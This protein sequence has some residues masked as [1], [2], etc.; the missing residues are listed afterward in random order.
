MSQERYDVQNPKSG[1]L[2]TSYS[3]LG[4]A[5]EDE[6]KIGQVVLLLISR[7][8]IFVAV[9]TLFALA[10]VAYALS[11][12]NIYEAKAV[13][14]ANPS[15][16]RSG[17]GG[18]GVGLAA[19]QSAPLLAL[20]GGGGGGGGNANVDRALISFR[21]RTFVLKMIKDYNLLPVIFPKESPEVL[22]SEEKITQAYEW[23]NAR[24][25][26][27]PL[28][29]VYNLSVKHTSPNSAF[30][31][32]NVVIKA[33]NDEEKARVVHEAS[34][35]IDHINGQLAGVNEIVIRDSLFAIIVEKT[36]ERAMAE[37]QEEYIFNV[38]DP[39]ILPKEKVGPI[40]VLIVLVFV[41]LGVPVGLFVVLFPSMKGIVFKEVISGGGV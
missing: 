28:M 11:R 20:M 8:K 32:A 34:H 30:K 4:G 19:L 41:A 5:A 14:V 40:R 7:W 36:Q 39:P 21:S 38:V 13:L 3:H 26:I 29:G 17:R 16:S 9:V 2:E 12:P 37:V 33:L 10:G 6:I 35:Q 1:G 18:G 25:Q 31:I 22:R 15:L 27:T 23:L 24:V